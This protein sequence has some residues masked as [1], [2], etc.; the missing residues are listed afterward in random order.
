MASATTAQHRDRPPAAV[1]PD[2][3]LDFITPAGMS[4]AHFR[5]MG[6]T[7]TLLLPEGQQAAGLDAV[8]T[9]FEEWE[10]TLSRFRTD[11]ELSRLNQQAGG[12]F[13]VSELLL[14]V[15]TEA[16]AAARAT[17]GIYDP[18]LLKQLAQLGYDR[19][20][21]EL[22][23]EL[24]AVTYRAQPGGAWRS[25]QVERKMRCVA[26][27]AG[28]QLDFGGIAKGM[29]VDAALERLQERGIHTALV[30]AG[31]DLAVHGLPPETDHWSIAI[32]GKD[33][34]WTIPLHH[35][36][37]ATSGLARRHWRQGEELRHH[38]LD[39][40]TG[41]PVH[42]GLWSVTAVAARCVQAEIAAKTAFILGLERGRAF[43]IDHQLAGLFINTDGT[44]ETGG[45]FPEQ[46]MRRLP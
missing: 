40:R 24:P 13:I 44:W 16:L 25:I 43:L 29:A 45:G 10:Q 11:S 7:I 3:E 27:P 6:T 32:Q 34:V 37:I 2:P 19:S 17:N 8:R 41:L 18:S 1:S 39:P 23:V 22:P 30:N 15:L 26:L 42:N 5:A 28:V 35:G 36:A 33:A 21:D 12:L 14:R 20:F 9:L 4:R 38:L 46:V 31:G